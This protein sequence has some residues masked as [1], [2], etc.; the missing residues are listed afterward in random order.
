[1]T[2]IPA[3]PRRQQSRVPEVAFGKK[4]KM[5]MMMMMMMMMTDETDNEQ[6]REKARS[7]G[8]PRECRPSCFT[9]LTWISRKSRSFQRQTTSRTAVGEVGLRRACGE[10]VERQGTTKKVRGISVS[11]RLF[12]PG[13]S[14][15]SM[16]ATAMD[17][18]AELWTC[19]RSRHDRM[20]SERI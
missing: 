17:Q 16:A 7:G 5:M 18:S 12:V 10:R 1:M 4:S 11:R 9:G 8:G 6:C 20:E 13:V 19:L 2:Q 15:S 3:Q 14:V